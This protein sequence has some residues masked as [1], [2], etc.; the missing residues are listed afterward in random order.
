MKLLTVVGARP[1][2]VKAAT[3]SRAIARHNAA[4]ALVIDE[5]IV[6][7]G[8]HYDEN[9][10]AVFFRE[11]GVP[12]PAHHLGIGSG[13]H[14]A[15]TGRMLERLEEVARSEAPDCVLVYGDTNST[16]A[17]ALA[18]AKLRIPVAH[19]EAGLRSYN[20]AMPEE[21]NRVVC[22]HVSA[23][24][25]CPTTAA[26]EN[27]RREGVTQGVEQ[28]GDV[29]Y[30]GML[31][32]RAMAGDRLPAALGVE[33]RRY[34]LA[35]VHR[36]ENT[37]RPDRLRDIVALLGEAARV[38]GP[39]LLPLH[40]RTRSALTR[41]GIALPPGV[42]A[43]EPAPYLHMIPLMAHARAI[44][45]DSGGMQKEAFFLEVPCLTLRGETE[46]VE[47]V[48]AG[49]NRLVDADAA[50]ATDALEAL[51]RGAWRADF[52]ARP[53]GSGHAAEAIVA[54]LVAAFA[55]AGA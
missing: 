30:D 47:T 11:L 14:G 2:F 49:A 13:S 43:I 37:D 36:A 15:Q 23:R 32:F 5:R 6:H 40:P 55:R 51:A 18:A 38:A 22:D 8:Q 4:S 19:V 34:L 53:Y 12:G 10:S 7:T 44:L 26:V 41:D 27:L 46:W 24:L 39:L 21:V 33:P 52:S 1:Q 20:R 50:L 28:V 3:V 48:E 54:S 35:T 42:R 9:L 29:M 16:L 25:Y 45:T 31:H 17:A